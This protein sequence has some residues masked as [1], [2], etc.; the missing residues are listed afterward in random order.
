MRINIVTFILLT[1]QYLGLVA[2]FQKAETAA[3]H[4]DVPRFEQKMHSFNDKTVLDVRTMDEYRQGHLAGAKLVDVLKPDF[5]SKVEGFDKTKPL[6]VYCASG[7][8]SEKAVEIL[9]RM[10][11]REI[12]ALE[13][14][15]RE[16]ASAGK[17]F[18]Q[19]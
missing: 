2:C 16:W 15:F 7:I 1:G 3:E 14:G 6:F 11:Y 13:G 17:P 5:A 4:L 9:D 12:Y 19:D 18:I 10:G 8:R